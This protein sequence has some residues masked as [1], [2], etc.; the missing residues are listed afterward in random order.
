MKFKADLLVKMADCTHAS[1]F[2][3]LPK[4][5]E[6]DLLKGWTFRDLEKKRGDDSN[7]IFSFLKD[8]ICLFTQ[9]E[10]ETQ[11][12]GEAGSPG[13]AP[14][15]T[16]SWASGIMPWAKGRLSATGVPATKFFLVSLTHMESKFITAPALIWRTVGKDGVWRAKHSRAS[17]RYVYIKDLSVISM[18]GRNDK[19]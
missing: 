11:A 13:E 1:T 7:K 6:N 2:T 8:F 17:K 9:R 3:Q 15:W 4:M 19:N 14:C 16:Q 5:A 12:E 10:V 18:P